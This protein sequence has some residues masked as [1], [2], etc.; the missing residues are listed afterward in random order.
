MIGFI[1]LGVD[2]DEAFH[3]AEAFF[4]YIEDPDADLALILAVEEAFGVTL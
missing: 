4:A 2:A 3:E 1:G